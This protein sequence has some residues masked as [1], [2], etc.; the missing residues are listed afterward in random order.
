MIEC[1]NINLKLGSTGKQVMQLQESLTKQGWYTGKIDGDF[2]NMTLTSVKNFQRKYGLL[3]DGIVGPVTCNKLKEKSINTSGIYTNYTLCEKSGGD[4]LGQIT[5]YH[6]GP[7]SIK[8]AL[9]KFGITGYSEKTIGGYAGTTSNGT[10]HQGLNTAIEY[11]ARREGVKLI[12]EW[13]NFSDLGKSRFERFKKLGELLEDE[14]I[15]I[16]W[17]EL[18]QKRWGHYS[19]AK[20]LNLNNS[21]LTVA[22]SLG[23][24][25]G[26]TTYCGY[27]ESRNFSTQESYYAGISQKSIC[28][29]R[30]L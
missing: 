21:L 2:G 19:L 18:Y 30:R 27:M 26:G 22:N 7:H 11:I 14:D 9:R 5:G 1:T 15:S 3:V 24:R 29:I 28:I 6:C 8:Q 10:G 4:C 23:S 13:M 20:R 12:V 25:C 16:F 17:H